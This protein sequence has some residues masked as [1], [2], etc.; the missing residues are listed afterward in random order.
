MLIMRELPQL[1]GVQRLV[2]RTER[3][4][5][6]GQAMRFLGPAAG[7]QRGRPRRERW[8]AQC[9]DPRGEL[10]VSGLPRPGRVL[11]QPPCPVS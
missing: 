7:Q 9:R 4:T 10:L 3:L 11:V 6:L 2:R 1:P 8:P 5:K